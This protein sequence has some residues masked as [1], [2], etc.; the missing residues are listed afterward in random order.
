[1]NASRDWKAAKKTAADS[2]FAL[3]NAILKD[4]DP[5][6]QKAV[7]AKINDLSG[8]FTILDDSIIAKI[9]DAGRE[10]DEERQIERNRV[11]AKAA[12][13]M[14]TAWRNHP[15][16]NVVDQNPF[17]AFTI[18]APVETVLTKF[19]SDFGI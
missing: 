16:A 1:M 4:C 2:M 13:D 3:K 15:L 6:L 11:L 8:I 18:R 10:P 19:V 14:L 7:K 12:G 9:E 17:G 5:E